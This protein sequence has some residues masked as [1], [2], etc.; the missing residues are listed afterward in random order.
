MRF[1]S[2][3]VL[4]LA[5]AV[6]LAFSV[7][8]LAN[9]RG[10][11][12]HA[13]SPAQDAT[14]AATT[15]SPKCTDP[16]LVDMVSKDA[17]AIGTTLKS[18]NDKSTAADIYAFMNQVSDA[19]IKYEDMDTPTDEGCSYL[20]Y[21]TMVWFADIGDLGQV[22]MGLQLNLDSDNISARSDAVVKRLQNQTKNVTDLHP[23]SK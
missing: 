20:A 16:K 5:V 17:L 1:R 8:P 19:R 3:S 9:S 15:S 23:T 12:V 22:L 18:M 10:S 21:E 4:G 7:I 13:N 6:L 11:T 14:A 2:F